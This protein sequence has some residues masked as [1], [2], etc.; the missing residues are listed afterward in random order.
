MTSKTT[1]SDYLY[2]P[3]SEVYGTAV[4]ACLDGGTLVRGRLWVTLV[5]DDDDDTRLWEWCTDTG[6]LL[7]TR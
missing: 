2:Q 1:D 4:S 6:Q 5:P 7:Q 3:P